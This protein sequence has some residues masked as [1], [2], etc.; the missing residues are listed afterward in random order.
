MAVSHE[1]RSIV[2]DSIAVVSVDCCKQLFAIMAR[3]FHNQ[4]ACSPLCSNYHGGDVETSLS[5]RKIVSIPDVYAI[6]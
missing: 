1:Y 3:W 4:P 2:E 5:F 6:N